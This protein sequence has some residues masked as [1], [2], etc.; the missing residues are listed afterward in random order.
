M[1]NNDVFPNPLEGV[2]VLDL[3]HVQSGPTCTTMLADMGA[4]VVKVEPFA[5]DQFRE[6]RDG[7]D[8]CNFN[9]NKRA[10]A[11]DLKTKDGKE[12]VFKLAQRADV[13]IENFLPGTAEKLGV[14]YEAL[15]R[16]SPKIIYCSISGYGQSGPFRDRPAYDPA[17]Q[18]MSGIMDC[19]GEPDRPPARMRPAMIDFGAGVNAAFAIAA[20]LFGREKT[21]R[22]QRIDVALLDV[23]IYAMCPYVT[24]F[25]RNGEIP[26]RAGSAQPASAVVQSFET[27]DGL[28]YIVAG[29]D[30]M[31]QKLCNALGIEEVGNDP[32]YATRTQRAELRLEIAEIITRET[33]KYTS[34]D[35]EEKLLT[36]G[37]ACAK[38]RNIGEIIQEPHVQ[39]R[40]ILEEVNHPD[41]GKMVTVKTPILF[42]GKAAPFRRHAPRLGEHTKEILK[43]LGYSEQEIQALIKG[44]AALQ[45]EGP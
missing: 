8:F 5:G 14:G 43:E 28:V 18:A 32:R 12:V 36:G 41:K 10:I 17:L 39:G 16:L 24:Q 30:R 3:S 2:K 38:V 9:R 23:A 33:R 29:A 7:A 26:Q 6:L 21:G 42:S 31:W 13:F 35:L 27:R 34:Q 19:T 40:G 11:L 15:S 22:G 37:V 44:S 45:Y 4:E 20:A 25:I 1:K